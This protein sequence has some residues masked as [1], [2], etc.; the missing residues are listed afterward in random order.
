MPQFTKSTGFKL[1]KKKAKKKKG[2]GVD[3]HAPKKKG[4]GKDP[5][6]Y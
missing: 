3:P 5:H 4:S 2:S 6:K 1:G